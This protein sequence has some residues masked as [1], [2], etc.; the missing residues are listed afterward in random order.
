M[1][2]R[3]S[4]FCPPFRLK[5]QKQK[6]TTWNSNSD[7]TRC[8]PSHHVRAPVAPRL[9]PSP[10]YHLCVLRCGF[11]SLH[12]F[13]SICTVPAQLTFKF[14]HGTHMTPPSFL[15]SN[16]LGGS[17]FIKIHLS[18]NYR[19]ASAT[20]RQL[21]YILGF[22]RGSTKGIGGLWAAYHRTRTPLHVLILIRLILICSPVRR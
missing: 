22:S 17:P 8:R 19:F 9:H 16:P 10:P 11:L 18:V 2:H 15:Y 6:T 5:K 3:L 13:V 4:A 14:L 7:I 1:H 20:I 12:V 21:T